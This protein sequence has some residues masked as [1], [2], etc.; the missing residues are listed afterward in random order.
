MNNLAN[1]KKLDKNELEKIKG[2]DSAGNGGDL[3]IIHYGK[4]LSLPTPKK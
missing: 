3:I 1:F 4:K 2:G